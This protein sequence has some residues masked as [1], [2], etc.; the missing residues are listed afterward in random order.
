MRQ[1]EGLNCVNF[2]LKWSE[3]GSRTSLRSF[4]KWVMSHMDET[5]RFQMSITSL[6]CFLKLTL[7]SSKC[8]AATPDLCVVIT[9]STLLHTFSI[10]TSI[11]W[12]I[13]LSFDLSICHYI[14]VSI[15]IHIYMCLFLRRPSHDVS[16]RLSPYFI[17]FFLDQLLWILSKSKDPIKR[18]AVATISRLLKVIGL[19]CKRA[20]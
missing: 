6:P 1:R 7:W 17:L 14:S 18:P 15:D 8:T 13:H 19:F 20:L 5:C 11:F 16:I 10:R 3:C 2:V 12:S 4:L 9:I